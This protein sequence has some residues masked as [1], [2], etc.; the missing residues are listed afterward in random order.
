[1]GKAVAKDAAHGKGT[2]VSLHG[3]AAVRAELAA[4]VEEATTLLAPYGDRAALLIEAARFIASR[5]R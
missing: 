1:M 5:R 3:V 2:L 4:L